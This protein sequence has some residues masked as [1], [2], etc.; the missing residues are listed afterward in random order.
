MKTGKNLPK[1][2]KNLH[3]DRERAPGIID[4]DDFRQAVA[5]ALK[6]ELGRTHQAIKTVMDW[7][8]AS[9]R[10]VKHWFAGTHGPSGHH[11]IAIIC[12]SDAVFRF[13]LFASGRPSL[14]IS[15]DMLAL[16]DRMIEL[17][18]QIDAC[19]QI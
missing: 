11:L 15:S 17:V 6:S 1:M 9:E 8:D 16:R 14:A 5:M 19:E 18:A 4:K 12:H 3:K 10:T 7:T 13:V 2:G